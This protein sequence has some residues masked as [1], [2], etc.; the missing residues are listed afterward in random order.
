[1]RQTRRSRLPLRV[2]ISQHPSAMSDTACLTA[3]LELASY[4]Q[5]MD[6]ADN[7]RSRRQTIMQALGTRLFEDT[8]L[9]AKLI[10]AASRSG[11]E[12]LYRA[13]LH[14]M[15]HWVGAY[16][17]SNGRLSEL[18]PHYKPSDGFALALEYSPRVSHH[19]EIL[20][21]TRP[22]IA[23]LAEHL[24]TSTQAIFIDA[25]VFDTLSLPTLAEWP[26]FGESPGFFF[27]RK[28]DCFD[29]AG[30][31]D[32][33]WLGENVEEAGH[34]KARSEW[35]ADFEK[36]F[37]PTIG[38]T[39]VNITWRDCERY[40][41]LVARLA[42]WPKG[43]GSIECHYKIGQRWQ[44]LTV[45]PRFIGPPMSTHVKSQFLANVDWLHDTVRELGRQHP[46]MH[47]ADCSATIF[48]VLEKDEATPTSLL[49]MVRGP[50]RDLLVTDRLW[51]SPIG[52]LTNRVVNTLAR[53]DMPVEVAD[54]TPITLEAAR[55]MDV[56]SP[57]DRSMR[58]P[59]M[60]TLR[61]VPRHRL[62]SSTS[63]A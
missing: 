63:E 26:M 52:E 12:G 47:I 56:A 33:H 40:D 48:V 62:P 53:Y 60:G 43:A 59:H 38:L 18:N 35:G 61:L 13:F 31:V 28:T 5:A 45:A 44:A 4:S 51:G 42:T 27:D 11:N 14:L 24:G 6:D 1:M 30:V 21:D 41:E 36:L 55:A 23:S 49:L 58:A 9:C 46:A 15:D 7:S 22:L 37:R 34:E 54:R 57:K 32:A 3:L 2:K 10:T 20:N 16:H 17:L 50:K 25:K 39:F 29:D 8:E 19:V